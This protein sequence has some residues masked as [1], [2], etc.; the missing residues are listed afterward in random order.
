[1]KRD[2]LGRLSGEYQEEIDDRNHEQNQI[3]AIRDAGQ[4]RRDRGERAIEKLADLRVQML[5]LELKL[6]RNAAWEERAGN[7]ELA[8]VN[9]RIRIAVRQMRDGNPIQD[10]VTDLSYSLRD[11]K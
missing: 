10:L 11:V 1:M 9:R 4:A 8:D 6:G 5:E 2:T 3:D 7:Y